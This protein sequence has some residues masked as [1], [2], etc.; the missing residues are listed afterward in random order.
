M[1]SAMFIVLKNGGFRAVQ[2]RKLAQGYIFPRKD[3]GAVDVTL[4]VE[5]MY[6]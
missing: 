3:F 1:R 2:S 5:A 6:G 4:Q